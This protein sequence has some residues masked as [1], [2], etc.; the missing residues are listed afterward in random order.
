MLGAHV[1]ED[2]ARDGQVINRISAGRLEFTD[3]GLLAEEPVTYTVAAVNDLGEGPESAEVT[4]APSPDSSPGFVPTGERLPAREGQT[5]RRTFTYAIATRGSIGANVDQFSVHVAHTLNDPRGWP[6]G[7]SIEFR[8]V[9]S[10]GDFTV[11]LA[12]AGTVPSFSSSC[13]ST[14]PAHD[15]AAFDWAAATG[16]LT[17]SPDGTIHPTQPLTRAELATALWHLAGSPIGLTPHPWTDTTPELA[18]ALNW[19]HQS[20]VITG[21]A[22]GTFRPTRNI[23]RAHNA[24][25]LFAHHLA[26]APPPA[27]APAT[28]QT[29]PATVPPTA[30]PLTPGMPTSAAPDTPPTAAPPTRPTPGEP[31]PKPAGRIQTGASGP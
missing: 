17:P 3:A 21:Y 31:V 19:V 14:L 28:S 5:E 10:G 2:R 23:T 18:D 20:G 1:G 25:A 26:T 16:V 7:G 4:V 30:P 22:D 13:S 27:A 11:W 15:A 29:A 12:Q 9:A 6:L 8:Q 24:K